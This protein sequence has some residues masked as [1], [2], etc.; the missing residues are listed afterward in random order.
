MVP[1]IRPRAP[2]FGENLIARILLIIRICDGKL[3][4]RGYLAHGLRSSAQLSYPD[5]PVDQLLTGFR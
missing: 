5:Y 4:R 3:A 2:V 1:V